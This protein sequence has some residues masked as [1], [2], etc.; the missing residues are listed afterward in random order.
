MVRSGR[1][2]S[3]G[4]FGGRADRGG[5]RGDDFAAR[6]N[7]R[8][9]TGGS[10]PRWCFERLV[11]RFWGGPSF[12]AY[13]GRSGPSAGIRV[14]VSVLDAFGRQLLGPGQGFG[15][16]DRFGP[17]FGKVRPP[18][19]RTQRG[20]CRGPTLSGAGFGRQAVG[21][22]TFPGLGRRCLRATAA[23]GWEGGLWQAPARGCAVPATAPRGPET[24]KPRPLARVRGLSGSRTS[25]CASRG[26]SVRRVPLPVQPW[27]S[28]CTNPTRPESDLQPIFVFSRDIYPTCCGLGRWNADCGARLSVS[29]PRIGG[30]G[31]GC[32][33][34]ARWTASVRLVLVPGLV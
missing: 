17:S 28:A 6:W 32:A 7:V 2:V 10:P 21:R 15:F 27:R 25:G 33:A 9:G 5:F 23:T 31:R 11:V 19:G 8:S 3:F 4:E 14:R 12:G 29:P 34:F 13:A 22:A 20:L 16:G 24:E 1:R 18:A 30:S 26:R